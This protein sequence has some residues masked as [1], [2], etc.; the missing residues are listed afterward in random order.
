[1]AVFVG[2]PKTFLA[3]AAP[4]FRVYAPEKI[5]TSQRVPPTPT[6]RLDTV[7]VPPPKPDTASNE[8][9]VRDATEV[10][11]PVVTVALSEDINTLLATIVPDV[12]LPLALRLQSRV[13]MLP[14]VLTPPTKTF[15]NGG[16]DSVPTTEGRTIAPI[17]DAPK[18]L[19][20]KPCV[21]VVPVML[22]VFA[23]MST[24]EGE[25]V[26]PVWVM[27]PQVKAPPI[28]TDISQ[29]F[30]DASVCEIDTMLSPPVAENPL[31]KTLGVSKK[32]DPVLF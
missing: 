29:G 4:Q 30:P 28:L 12:R 7:I 26:A 14:T 9:C 5:F 20:V 23:P 31:A 27:A 24:V 17:V 2:E 18:E 1:M 22:M 21:V 10:M 15:A 3:A 25:K 11:A 32:G 8:D 19:L 16:K 13:V 6:L